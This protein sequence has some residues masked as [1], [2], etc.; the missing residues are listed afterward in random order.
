MYGTSHSSVSAPMNGIGGDLVDGSGTINPAAL[1]TN[2][3]AVILP[4]PS[5]GTSANTAPRGIKRSRT[6]DQRG[7]SRADGD[8]DDAGADEHGRRKRGRPPKTPRP[9]ATAIGDQTTNVHMQTPR[10]QAQPL[11]H[12]AGVNVSPPQA[13][14]PDKTTPT[15][16]T[17]VKALPTVRDHTTDQLNEEGDEY[18]PKEFDEAGEK[19]VNA[20][21]YLTGNREYKCRTF[22]VP[23]RG[24]KLFMLATECARV[25]G[26]RDSY[27]LF[28]KN[29]S[30]HK[31]IAT[32]IEKD[33]LIQ[34]DILPYSYRS[35][36][37]AIVTARSMFR[38]FGS[39]VIVNGRRV[40]DDYWEGKARKQ[41]FTEDDL[42]GEKRPGGAKA[43]DAAAAEA[44]SAASLLPA[45]AHGD[46]IYSNALEAM[47]NS[48]PLGP[49]SSV[50]LAPLPM[51]HMAT[52]TDDPRLREYNS[53][54]RARQEL[55]GQP[56][57]DRTQ[58][59]SAAEILNQA[60][61]TADFNKILS[62]QRSYRQKGLEDFYSK[63]REIPASAAQ[64]QP[65][66]LDSAPSASQPLQSPQIASA[67]MMNTTQ[68]QQAMLPHQT[69]MI[70]GQPGLQQ[71]VAHPQAPVG[72]SP[73]R[74]G[75]AVRP[76]LM[77]QRSNPSLSAGTPQPSG[78]YGY[79]SQPQQMWGQPPPQPQP[80][81]LSA[82]GPQA[83]GMPQYASQL[84]AQ[85]QHSPSPLAQH[86]SQSPR[87]QPRP[88]AP[89]MPQAF[90]LHHP[91]APQQQPM[92]SMG[93]PGGTAA[94]YAAMTAARGMYPST[95]GPGGQQFMAGTP[96]QPGLA[97][98]MSAGGAMPGWA[99][100]PGGPIQPGH[101]QPGQSGAPLGWSGY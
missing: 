74:T 85:Q 71:A 49:P 37:I 29:R 3:V 28:N 45:L 66:Q 18:I 86:P 84:H 64:S 69:P 99:P 93:F 33:D 55:T 36:Q 61:H 24:T 11:P 83:V 35:R 21:G 70:P 63:Q 7:L 75:P 54:P 80:S 26:Y 6:P 79:P 38:Q 94:P 59:S 96:Q 17:L 68:P 91:Q 101:P 53:M 62:S 34:Q 58:P 100:T 13:S 19:K 20:M 46:V 67:S 12:Q 48:L 5:F 57:Q 81:P 2:S 78:P 16:S 43:R 60:S 88:S 76:D 8:H 1:N 39:R 4:T 72:Q 30:L 42:A 82:A 87:N 52:T 44:A 47:P 31:I 32:Q 10:M 92:A 50:S 65:G 23:H 56:Y 90:P 15:K 73:A 77:H 22:R 89:Q 14:P 25:L 51:I 27:L 41:G 9:S 97:M 40:R 95:Q 98:G